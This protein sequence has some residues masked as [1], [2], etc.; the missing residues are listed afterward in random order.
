VPTVSKHKQT[1]KQALPQQKAQEF[2]RWFWGKV[3][4]LVGANA[5]LVVVTGG[6][7]ACVWRIAAAMEEYAGRSSNASIRFGFDLLADIK[8][9]YTV[10]IAVGTTGVALY[11]RERNLHRQTRERLT[12]RI[13]DLEIR[14]DPSRRSSKLTSQG[15]T[16]EDDK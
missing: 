14:I 9:V 3:F 16:R 1:A 8:M 11:V 15:L 5:R 2:G 10:S 4:A 7:C 12:A 6:V 13:T